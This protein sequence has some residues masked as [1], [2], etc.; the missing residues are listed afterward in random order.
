MQ[1]T[2]YKYTSENRQTLSC[3]GTN[4]LLTSSNIPKRLA[5]LVVQSQFFKTM[6]GPQLLPIMV[7][8]QLQLSASM[9]DNPTVCLHRRKSTPN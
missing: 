6:V 8:P 4:R 3:S 1:T 2:Q 5:H 9:A 7:G